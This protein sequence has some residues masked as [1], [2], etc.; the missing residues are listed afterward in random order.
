MGCLGFFGKPATEELDTG[1]KMHIN[2][3]YT[4]KHDAGLM[5]V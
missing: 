3:Y 4:I 5:K 1:Q 2:A